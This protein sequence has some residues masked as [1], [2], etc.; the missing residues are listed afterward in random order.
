MSR[1]S[2]WTVQA[3]LVA[4]V[5]VS[6][7]A[8]AH[9]ALTEGRTVPS[10]RSPSIMLA[11]ALAA[12]APNV[13][14]NIANLHQR[15]AIT[16]AQEPQFEAFANVLRQ[17]A[18]MMPSGPSPSLNAVER[19]RTG[20]RFAQQDLEGMRRMLPPL[21]ALYAVLSPAQRQAADQVFSQGP[22]G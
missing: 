7:A 9:A 12:P 14:A 22:G 21:Q 10:G 20:I 15:L 3:G 1:V 19:L 16:P 6:V 17:N 4:A 5:S 13:E 18:R 8:L 11:Q 2:G